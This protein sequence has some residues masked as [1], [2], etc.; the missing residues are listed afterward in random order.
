MQSM[1]EQ[2]AT[3]EVLVTRK[4]DVSALVHIE[5]AAAQLREEVE[6][7][8]A[9]T[10]RVTRAESLLRDHTRALDGE[11]RRGARVA[12]LLEQVSA[13][14]AR[15]ADAE[16][17]ER[18]EAEA[19]RTV[20]A[21]GA[22]DGRVHRTDEAWRAAVAETRREADAALV[23]S[24]LRCGRLGGSGGLQRHPSDN[25]RSS[26]SLILAPSFSLAH[27]RE[28]SARRCVGRRRRFA[29]RWLDWKGLRGARRHG[30]GARTRRWRLQCGRSRRR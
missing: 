15:K 11:V 24:R 21:L 27:C 22:L 18:L 9:L 5:A 12:E 4:A 28:R 25:Q 14:L 20:D 8:A 6:Q 10:D 30:R 29:G 13:S 19:A 2:F 26:R 3:L 23:R 7:R 1:R 17:L 16:R